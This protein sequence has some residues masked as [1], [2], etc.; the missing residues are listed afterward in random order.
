MFFLFFLSTVNVLNSQINNKEIL[1]HLNPLNCDTCFKS[2]SEQ[3]ITLNNG[4]LD[5]DLKI[6]LS[7][8]RVANEL[9]LETKIPINNSFYLFSFSTDNPKHL[10]RNGCDYFEYNVSIKIQLEEG[11][12][13]LLLNNILNIELSLKYL[14]ENN[15][16]KLLDDGYSNA[17]NNDCFYEHSDSGLSSIKF[18][19]NLCCRA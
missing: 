10:S 14:D 4:S 16:L 18:E 15:N 19:V 13:D 6:V 2:I 11:I 7:Q 9:Y 1:S 8:S 3:C 17:L 5:L 12:C